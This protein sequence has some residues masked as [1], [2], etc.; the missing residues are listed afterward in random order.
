MPVLY[1][2]TPQLLA[3]LV[4][5][6]SLARRQRNPRP[7]GLKLLENTTYLLLARY[8]TLD[9]TQ[10][11]K[12]NAAVSFIINLPITPIRTVNNDGQQYSTESSDKLLK[13]IKGLLDD[14]QQDEGFDKAVSAQYIKFYITILN[15]RRTFLSEVQQ[16]T[17]VNATALLLHIENARTPLIFNEL[18]ELIEKHDNDLND[19][20]IDE[21]N[22]DALKVRATKL[23]GEHTSLD[24]SQKKLLGLAL[25]ASFF[26]EQYIENAPAFSAPTDYSTYKKV[27]AASLLTV[28]AVTL[29]IV[30]PSLF[31]AI[32]VGLLVAAGWRIGMASAIKSNAPP[33]ATVVS[34]VDEFDPATEGSLR[35]MS[36]LGGSHLRPTV[37][38]EPST[39]TVLTTPASSVTPRREID[40]RRNP[41]LTWETSLNLQTILHTTPKRNEVTMLPVDITSS[42]GC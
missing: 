35:T 3:S 30:L 12:V 18:A 25:L 21:V 38:T 31:T 15:S 8:D 37:S 16:Q 40:T 22:T 39:V 17:L 9:P 26:P 5:E 20:D 2:T 1:Q 29:A 19:P 27:A 4:R 34:A 36:Q 13:R 7:D 14:L 32:A 24:A 23:L 41:R 28:G 33:V 42:F 10:Q 11:L 6:L